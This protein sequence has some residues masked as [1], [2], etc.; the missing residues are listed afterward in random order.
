MYVGKWT[1]PKLVGQRPPPC[2]GVTFTMI[3][4]HR[5]LL[6]GGRQETGRV[7]SVYIFDFRELVRPFDITGFSPVILLL[8]NAVSLWGQV[9]MF[10]VHNGSTW[11]PSDDD[12]CIHLT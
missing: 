7:S 5:A 10:I 4:P 1:I 8:G 6:F 9:A 11:G 3:D 2:G 12:D